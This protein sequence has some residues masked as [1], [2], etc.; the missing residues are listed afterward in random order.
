LKGCRVVEDHNV[1]P[2]QLLSKKYCETAG[3]TLNKVT[4]LCSMIFVQTVL[5]VLIGT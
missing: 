1:R 3:H 5:N 2:E 4:V